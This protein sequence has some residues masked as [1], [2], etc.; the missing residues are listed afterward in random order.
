MKTGNICQICGRKQP[1]VELIT[2]HGIRHQIEDLIKADYPDWND[3][4]VICKE[5]FERYRLQYIKSIM[6]EEES[7]LKG[8][9]AEVIES[10]KENEIIAAN[11]N[12]SFNE[13]LTVG[14]K[15]SDKVAG[16]GGSWPFIIIFLGLL[17]VWIALNSIIVRSFDPFPFILLNLVLSCIAAIQAPVIMMSQNRQEKK[18]RERA[19]NDYKVNLKSELEIRTL[20]EKVDH[21]LLVQWAKLMEI[22]EMQFEMMEDIKKE[23]TKKN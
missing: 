18:D 16:F 2:G 13:K 4:D 15:I 21:L 9:E 12:Q 20:H 3:C 1:E 14:E 19:E 6:E 11:I 10:I 22:Q 17:L 8:L 23:I 5:D 7:E